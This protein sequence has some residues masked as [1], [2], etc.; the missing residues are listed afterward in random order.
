MSNDD[1]RA[2]QVGHC[3]KNDRD[4]KIV[5]AAFVI[6]LIGCLLMLVGVVWG[7]YE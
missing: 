5:D 4:I 3:K 2:A 6:G 1:K 7:V